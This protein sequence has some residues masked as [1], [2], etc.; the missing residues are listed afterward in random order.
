MKARYTVKVLSGDAF[1]FFLRGSKMLAS[2]VCVCLHV[3]F[4]TLTCRVVRGHDIIP[5][6]KPIV[7]CTKRCCHFQICRLLDPDISILPSHLQLRETYLYQ[8]S[9]S[10][11][12]G[13]ARTQLQTLSLVQWW[14]Q[15]ILRRHLT[16]DHP[17]KCCLWVSSTA[18]DIRVHQLM[19]VISMKGLLK[20]LLWQAS[21]QQTP[22]ENI[23]S[24][25]KT[26]QMLLL[27]RSFD[28][29]ACDQFYVLEFLQQNKPQ[30]G[31]EWNNPSRSTSVSGFHE[32]L[33]NTWQSPRVESWV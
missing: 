31:F 23:G 32:Q 11:L 9:F 4:L 1:F 26:A 19:R 5:P 25:D 15:E 6:H 27:I 13:G 18:E 21:S 30:Q 16:S 2:D 33:R 8:L 10:L 12:Y 14:L 29:R 28:S 20:F 3:V 7:V 24:S 17:S 22:H